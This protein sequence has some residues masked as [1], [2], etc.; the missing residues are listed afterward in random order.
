MART[1]YAK[2]ARAEREAAHLLIAEG[3]PL[4]LR[5]AGSK[6]P[7]DLVAFQ[8]DRVLLIQ[9]KSGTASRGAQRQELTRLAAAAA[10]VPPSAACELWLRRPRQ[11]FTR[12][13]VPRE[14]PT[15]E[16]A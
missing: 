3:W 2:G 12:L 8:G 14:Q 9:V 11:G 7:F 13:A 16:A 4:V 5:S 15:R 1:N 10:H 6:S